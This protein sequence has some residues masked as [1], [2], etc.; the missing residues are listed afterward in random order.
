MSSILRAVLLAAVPVWPAA[1]TV[2]AEP[3]PAAAEKIVAD[4]LRAWQVP[5][6][7]VVVVRGDDTLLLKGFGVR[8][9]RKAD[10]VT[11]DTVFPLA[12]CSKAFTSALIAMLVDDEAL[13]WDDRVSKHL[14]GFA[15]SDPNA[16]ALLTVRDLL[17][18][19]TGIG[20]H[21]LLWYRAPWGIDETLRRAKALPLDYPFRSG[22]AYTSVPVLAAGRYAEKRTGKKWEELVAARVCEPLGMTGVSF[23]TKGI[24]KD[25]ER[26]FGHK[27]EKDG[28]PVVVP[29]YEITEPNPAGSVNATARDLAA[30]LKFHLS[31][32]INPNGTR[33]VSVKNLDETKA[34]HTPVRL[35][36]LAKALNP[37]TAQLS[38]CMGWLCYDHRGKKVLSH[39]GMIDGFRVQVTLVPGENLGVAVLANLQETRMNAAVTNAL[40]DLYCDLEARDWN[41][42]FRKVA[43]Q[44]AADRRAALEVRDASRKPDA[45]PSLP[46][47]NYAGEYANPAYGTLT[48]SC[49]GGKLALKWSSFACPLEQFEADTFRVTSGFFED[50][51]VTFTAAEGKATGVR[52]ADQEFKKK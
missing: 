29:W 43:D 33:I 40:V 47:A 49:A 17:S 39:G 30:W 25:A 50:R 15:L 23:T 10:K 48:V 13:A 31:D 44:E 8:E 16:N 3:D 9:A 1:P 37:D 52:F 19:R 4:A 18:H 38:Y 21:D 6:A 36:G 42:F 2:A 14:P 28:K 51:L 35:D 34:P 11:P 32:G 24:P 20:G 45:K 41:A 27:L 5:G 26:S 46:L 12:S 22:F 7:A